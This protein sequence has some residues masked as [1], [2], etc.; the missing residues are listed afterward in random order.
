MTPE[1]FEAQLEIATSLYEA[2]PPEKKNI[3]ANASKPFV[4]VPRSPVMV[5][6]KMASG[7]ECGVSVDLWQRCVLLELTENCADSP[8]VRA[9]LTPEEVD[10]LVQQ[11]IASRDRVVSAESRQNGAAGK[12]DAEDR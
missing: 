10:W 1:E 6:T 8:V 3:L 11:L 5:T 4:E 12:V 9:A 7:D 2:R